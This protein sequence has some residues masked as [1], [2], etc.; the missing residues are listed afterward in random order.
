MKRPILSFLLIP[1]LLCC[2]APGQQNGAVQSS[3]SKASTISGKVSLDGRSL[4]ERSGQPWSVTNPDALVGR[5]DRQVK[6]KCRITPGSHDI[7]V[8][9]VKT[10]TPQST[11]AINLGDAAFRR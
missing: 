5:Q 3:A 7:F 11:Y 1:L 4:I 10:A 9:S 8:L 6:V 2:C